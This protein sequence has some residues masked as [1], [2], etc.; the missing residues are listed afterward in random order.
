MP[1]RIY[2]ALVLAFALNACGNSSAPTKNEART[3]RWFGPT[4]EQVMKA[5]ADCEIQN[6]ESYHVGEES[7]GLRVKS[8]VMTPTEREC[9]KDWQ[10]EHNLQFEI[11]AQTH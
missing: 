2:M 11:D 1:K 10:K 9:L 7:N 3:A 6:V 5:A 8:G 4:P